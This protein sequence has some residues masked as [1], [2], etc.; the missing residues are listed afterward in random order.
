MAEQM[1]VFKGTR[2][3]VFL[4]IDEEYSLEIIKNKIEEKITSA[5]TFFQGIQDIKIKGTSLSHEDLEQLSSWMKDTYGIKVKKAKDEKEVTIDQEVIKEG[6]TKFI[7]STLRSGQ[8]VE[9]EGNIVIIGDVNPGA[10]IIATGN[11]IIM[12]T[13][14]GIAHAGALGNKYAVVVSLLLQPTQ[15]RIAN[16]IARAPDQQLYKPTCPEKACVNEE[17]IVIIPYYKNI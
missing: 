11:I 2:D 5:R 17:K 13:L 7:Y 10:E 1:V 12:G 14:R 8:R 9:F 16:I 6:Q 15:L 3:G 4:F